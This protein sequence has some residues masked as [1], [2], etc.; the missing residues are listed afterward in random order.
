MLG[1]YLAYLTHRHARPASGGANIGD[2]RIQGVLPEVIG[3]PPGDLIQQVRLYSTPQRRSCQDS[4]LEFLILPTT[5]GALR[6]AASRRV[7]Y[8]MTT[9]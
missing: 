3:L 1:Q 4:E 2:R 6:Q 8:E 5:E 7:V 9:S